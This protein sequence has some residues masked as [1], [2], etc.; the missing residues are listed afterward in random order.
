MRTS[1]HNSVYTEHQL[2]SHPQILCG[3]TA[4]GKTSMSMDVAPL[5]TAEIISADSRQIYRGLNIGT[6]KPAP[7]ELAA[8][9]QHFVDELDP[10]EAFSAG[11][12]ARAAEPRIQQILDRGLT[13]LVVGGSTLYIDALVNGFADIP[14]VDPAVRESLNRRL[15]SEGPDPLFRELREADPEAAATMDPTKSQRIVRA[16]EVYLGTGQPLSHFHRH[17]HKPAFTYRGIILER[18]RDD[19]YDRIDRRV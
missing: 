15:E 1:Q 16:L 7:E 9:P 4:I 12:F 5:L 19:L 13:P 2:K 3:P 8:V 10:H 14:D 17:H 6:A 11:E 18:D